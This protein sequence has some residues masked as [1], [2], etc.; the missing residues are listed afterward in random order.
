MVDLVT[1]EYIGQRS[2]E[3]LEPEGPLCV[4]WDGKGT[5]GEER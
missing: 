4:G 5:E 3:S 2:K 1:Q